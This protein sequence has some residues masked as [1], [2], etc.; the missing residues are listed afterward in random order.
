[1]TELRWIGKSTSEG[2]VTECRFNLER[3]AGTIPGILWSPIKQEG[4]VPLILM[5]HG[6]SGHKRDD[7]Q[8]LLGRRFAGAFQMAAASIDGPFHGD[9]VS[10][11]LEPRQYQE[12][13]AATGIDKV[14]DGMINDWCATLDTLS[15][16]DI[17][18]AD[19][20]AYIGLSMGTRFG[21]PL[22]SAVSS[23]LRCSVLGKN[24]MRAPALLNMAPRFTQDAPKITIPVLFHMQWNDELFPRDGQ[25]EL[26]DLL[27]SHDKRLLAFPGSHSTTAPA[28]IEAW[29]E[30]LAHYL[31]D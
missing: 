2:G 10:T 14:T 7:R 22:V 15:Q 13:M 5:G 17:I 11:P 21:L 31:T 18:N 24:G 9:R 12:R 28:A 6:G 29:C 1:M 27:G 16:L 30:F 25:F 23:R 20:I 4:P 3:E 19:R 8:L 26:F